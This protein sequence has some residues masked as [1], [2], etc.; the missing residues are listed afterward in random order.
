MLGY[1][2][3]NVCGVVRIRIGK[4]VVDFTIIE[5][6]QFEVEVETPQIRKLGSKDVKIP[7][8]LLMAAIV[9]EAIRPDL[10][11]RELICNDYW[12]F[13]PAVLKGTQAPDMTHGQCAVMWTLPRS[14]TNIKLRSGSEVTLSSELCTAASAM[15]IKIGACCRIRIKCE[16]TVGGQFLKFRFLRLLLL[17]VG[18]R[19]LPVP[20]T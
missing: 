19:R 12:R 14:V 5:A 18:L 1:R 8:R 7:L 17:I 4:E 15:R 3:D 16:S 2:R 6:G 11:R 10:L 20:I 13:R 9:H